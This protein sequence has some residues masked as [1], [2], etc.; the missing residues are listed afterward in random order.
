MTHHRVIRYAPRFDSHDQ[1]LTYARA[2]T[3]AWLSENDI[4]QSFPTAE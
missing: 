3:C 4:R 2:Q 1:A